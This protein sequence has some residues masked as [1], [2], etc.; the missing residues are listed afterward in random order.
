MLYIVLF[1]QI[2]GLLCLK[3]KS[4]LNSLIKII[5][6]AGLKLNKIEDISLASVNLKN[7]MSKYHHATLFMSNIGNSL[8]NVLIYIFI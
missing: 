6:P 7:K 3:K 2:Y 1:L 4:Q 8:I 5:N